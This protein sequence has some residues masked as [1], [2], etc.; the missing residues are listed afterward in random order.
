[1]SGYTGSL[2]IE[3]FEGTSGC[4]S[5]TSID[6]ASGTTPQSIDVTGATASQTYYILVDGVGGT[7]N[8]AFSLD[9]NITSG[10]SNVVEGVADPV[11]SVTPDGG[12][13]PFTANIDNQTL[14]NGTS[15]NYD[16]FI[17]DSNFTLI[18]S[19]S[20]TSGADTTFYFPTIGQYKILLSL[21]NSCL[22]A[23]STSVDL[24]SQ[25]LS[26][27]ITAGYDPICK[28]TP[29]T[30]FPSASLSP[31]YPT[32]DAFP[33]QWEWDFGDPSSGVDNTS[34]DQYPI[35]TF[36]GSGPYVTENFT[37]TLI[38]QADCGPD[39][40]TY[41]I[42]IIPRPNANPNGPL[43]VCS[44][45]TPE[46][47]T[48]ASDGT[49]PYSV[50]W[51]GG[52]GTITSP[53][54]DTTTVTGL[55]VGSY[56]FD[57]DITDGIGCILDSVVDVTVN[58]NPTIDASS[59]TAM[60]VC[61]YADVNLTSVVT[62]SLPYVYDW[63][64]TAY[65]DD[66]SSATPTANVPSSM[67]IY[68]SVTDA[69]GCTSD[70]D[71]VYISIRT[72]PTY[73][74]PFICSSAPLPRTT[75]VTMTGAGVGSTF[76][77]F[78]SPDYSLISGTSGA[79]STVVTIDFSSSTAGDYDFIVISTD[80]VTGCIDTVTV[81]VTLSAGITV[82]ATGP[83]Q[84]CLNDS[85][86]LSA[87]GATS[88]V[89]TV[90]PAEPSL[91]GQD[92]IA[93]PTTLPA[94]AN[95]YTYTVTGTTGQCT[96]EDNVTT[97]VNPLPIVTITTTDDTICLAESA[98]LVAGG[99]NVYDWSSFPNDPSLSGQTGNAAITVTPTVN[100]Q[101]CVTGTD[102]NNCRSGVCKNVIILTNNT[103]SA[104]ADTTICE[105][106][107][108]TLS[109]SGGTTYV[110]YELPG[111]ILVGASTNV[112]VAPAITTEY[113]VESVIS[114]CVFTDT[115]EVT[116]N[117]APAVNITQSEDTICR[118][119][120]LNLSTNGSDIFLWSSTPADGTLAGQQTNSSVTVFP[121]FNTTYSVTVTDTTSGCADTKQ[122]SVVTLATPTAIVAVIDTVCGCDTDTLDGT[123][124]T[125]SM[126]YLWTTTSGSIADSSDLITTIDICSTVTITLTVTNPA[127]GCSSSASTTAVS[128]LLP[129]AVFSFDP[130]QFC[131]GGVITD[132]LD[133][134]GSDVAATY[135]WSSNPAAIS[136]ADSFALITT[137]DVSVQ[138][139]FFLTVTK[140][141]CDS[142]Y[143]DTLE[144][145]PLPVVTANSG[146]LCIGDILLDTFAITGAGAG[147]TYD[148]SSSPD[149]ATIT[150]FD[151]TDSIAYVDYTLFGAGTYNYNIVVVD[152][153][154]GCEDTVLFSFTVFSNSITLTLTNDTT[155]CE[156]DSLQLNVSGAATYVWTSSPADV[157][158][159]GQ[160]SISNPK[161]LATVTTT[162]YVTAYA[163]SCF[164]QDSLLVTVNPIPNIDVGND[165]SI[166]N[167]SNLV[168]TGSGGTSYNWYSLPG[169][170]F[171]GSGVSIIVSPTSLTSFYA[172]GSLSGCSSRDT[173]EVDI[174]PLPLID[175]T[176]SDDTICGGESIFF[177]LIGASTYLWSSA[178]N[179]ASLAGQTTSAN[180]T[181]TPAI[182]TVYTIDG[183]DATTGCSNSTN[184]TVVVNPKPVAAM[185]AIDDI[186]S[187]Q[188]V[189]L[190]GSGSTTSLTYLWTSTSGSIADDT[191]L[192]TTAGICN[193]ST[194]SLIVT[195]TLT[196]CSDTVQTIVNTLTTPNAVISVTSDSFCSGVSTVVTLSGTGS[197]AGATY[198]WTASPSASISDTTALN[199]TATIT[200]TTVFTFT[201][202]KG[203]C[204]SVVTG[205][206]ATFT[207]P[208]VSSNPASL[209]MNDVLTAVFTVNGA[210]SG[211]S[212]DWDDS[213][214]LATITGFSSGNKV[215]DVDFTLFG[216]GTYNYVII[217]TDAVTGCIDTI[218][219]SFT[220]FSNNITLTLTNDTSICLLDTAE[221]I[222]SGAATYAWTASPADASLTGQTTQDT[223]YLSPSA[224]TKYYVTGSAGSCFKNDSV[225]ISILSL[226]I[227]SAGNDDTICSGTSAD[228]SASGTT[229]YEWYSLP[230]DVLIASTQNTSVSPASTTSYFVIGSDGTCSNNDT[231]KINVISSPNAVVTTTDDSLCLGDNTLLQ[232][233]GANTYLWSAV[234]ADASLTGQT[235]LASITVN[236]TVTTT[237][238]VVGTST[239]TGCTGTTNQI[240][241]VNPGLT[242]LAAPINNI[243]GCENV[244][245][246]GTGSTTSNT[247]FLWNSALSSP[248]TDDSDLTTTA[249]VCGNDII[250]LTVT[251]TIGNCSAIDTQTVTYFGKPDVDF[252]ANPSQICNGVATL[253]TL[254]GIADAGQTYE[255][256]SNPVVT[257]NNSNTLNATTTIS[258][259][260]IFSLKVTDSNGC[261]STYSDTVQTFSSPDITP[262]P[263]S[264]CESDILLDTLTISGP[265]TGSTID[266]SASPDLASITGFNAANTKA[267]TDYT[268]F[269]AG[270]YDYIITITDAITGCVDV[271]NY[272]FT[273]FPSAMNL[274]LSSDPSAICQND[275]S[276][277]TVSGA[278]TYSWSAS[279][280]DGSLSGQTTEDTIEVSPSSTT[281]YIVVGSAG[282]CTVTDTI[283]LTVLSIP[284]FDLGP[285]DTIICAGA[286]ISL[287]AS[288]GGT[289]QWFQ[290]PQDSLV[291]TSQILVKT[292][293]T[294][295]TYYVIV[296]GTN[297]CVN[298]DTIAISVDPIPNLNS[299]IEQDT[300]CVHDTVTFTAS[301]TDSFLWSALPSDVT[302]TG[303]ETD[304]IINV[305]PDTTTV[306]TLSGTTG[307]CT[308]D[309]V[310]TLN[311]KPGPTITVNESSDS[312]CSKATITLT[313]SGALAYQ[314]TATP[315]DAT[316]TG[317]ET[318][319][320]INVNPEN[321]TQYCAKGTD[322]EGCY[323]ISCKTITTLPLPTPD[324]GNDTTVC[325]D[326]V[327]T[328]TASGG[329]SYQW[330]VLSNDSLIG[331]SSIVNTVV[332]DTTDYYVL[333]TAANGC[334]N[335]DTVKV[336]VIPFNA[337][338]SIS[339]DTLCT[340]ANTVFTASG[341]DT[342]SWSA[343]PADATL[344]L[345]ESTSSTIDVTPLV[346]TI[347]TLTMTNNTTGCDKQNIY[348][349]PVYAYPAA[350]AAPI[351]DNCGCDAVTLDG[352]G[353]APLLSYLWISYSG[354]AVITNS[355]S[356]NASAVVCQDD[357]LQIIVTNTFTG[358]VSV[359]TT[360][361]HYIPKPNATADASPEQFCQ[362]VATTITLSGTVDSAVSYLWTAVPSVVIA[363]SSQ[364]NTT[365]IVSSET[366]FTLTLTNSSG[367]DTSIT[368]TVSAYPAPDLIATPHSFCFSNP[369][370]DLVMDIVGAS[371]GSTYNWFNVPACVTPNVVG[372]VSSQALNFDAC[373]AGY[374]LFEVEITDGFTGCVDSI[375][376]IVEIADSVSLVLDPEGPL[377]ICED[378]SL[379]ITAE[380]AF[381]FYWSTGDSTIADTISAV[382]VNPGLSVGSNNI[383]VTGVTGNCIASDTVLV[384][385]IAMPVADAG[386]N[387]T[388]CIDDTL[389]LTASNAGIGAIYEWYILPEDSLIGSGQSL[390]IYHDTTLTY[391]YYIKVTQTSCVSAD[392]FTV[393]VLERPSVSIT[394]DADTVCYGEVLTLIA[395]PTGNGPFSYLWNDSDASTSQIVTP[396]ITANFDFCVLLTDNSSGCTDTA[397]KTTISRDLPVTVAAAET[398]TSCESDD[399][400]LF[401]AG[402]HIYNW[403]N[404][405][406]PGISLG[407]T[408]TITVS[409]IVSACYVLTGTDTTTGCENKDTVCLIV[410]A[411]PIAHAGT[412]QSICENSSVTLS[413]AL[414]SNGTI[415]W[416]NTGNGFFDDDNIQN[417]IYTPG[418]GDA[419]TTVTLT[420]TVSNSP[421]VDAVSTIDIAVENQPFAAINSADPNPV[422]S[423]DTVDLSGTVTFGTALWY[424]DGNGLLKNQTT[425]TPY[426]ISAISDIGIVNAYM[427][428]TGLLGI[429]DDAL[430]SVEIEIKGIP[431]AN[432]GVNDAICEGDVKIFADASYNNGGIIWNTSGNGIFDSD[433]IEKPTYTHGS[434]DIG[435]TIW[436]TM[437]VTNAPCPTDQ[438]TSLL[439]IDPAPIAIIDSIAEDTICIDDHVSIYGSAL[440]VIGVVEWSDG[441]TAGT[442]TNTNG[443]TTDYYPSGPGVVQIYFTVKGAETCAPAIDTITLLVKAIPTAD[444][445]SGYPAICENSPLLLSGATSSNGTVSWTTTGSG[446]FNDSTLTN[447]TYTPDSGEAGF[448][449]LTIGVSNDPCQEAID[450]VT[451]EISPAPTSAILSIS[452]NH[453]CEGTQVT[454]TAAS[455]NA[456]NGTAWSDDNGLGTFGSKINSTTTT[457]DAGAIGNITIYYT[458]TGSST[459]TSAVDSVILDVKAPPYAYI[460]GISKD[461]TCVGLPI[462]IDDSLGN[463]NI[464]WITSGVG[465]F[466]TSTSTYTPL[467]AGIAFLTVFVTNSPCPSASAS[468][469]LVTVPMPEVTIDPS[470]TTICFADT[471]TISATVDPNGSTVT[472]QWND[473]NLAASASV[474]VYPADTTLYILYVLNDGCTVQDSIVVNVIPPGTPDAGIDTFFCSGDAITLNGNIEYASKAQW[475][476]TG[477]G[478]FTPGNTSLNTNY[479][480]TSSES[481]GDTLSFWLTTTDACY[482]K[483]DTIEIEILGKGTVDAGPDQSI[484]L[485]ANA[486]LHGQIN[487]EGN[488]VWTSSGT[489]D[490]YP[491]DT[492]RNAKYFP[493]QSDYENMPITLTFSASTP[494]A[495]TFDAMTLNSDPVT[496]PTVV[497]P[498]PG[499]PGQN[500]VLEIGGIEPG[501]A[502]VII[503]NKWGKKVFEASNY[504]NNWDAS[505]VES[506]VYY[507]VV[508]YGDIEKSA[509]IMILREEE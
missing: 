300:M 250:T 135:E 286:T 297:T 353:S 433:T 136:I 95:T 287:T 245:L 367:C 106:D 130:T 370:L 137:A 290:L 29:V 66:P 165:T 230:A 17:F 45:E 227:V 18:S 312:I 506:N 5:L 84:A 42:S 479:N 46:L 186:C 220:V 254:S 35:H 111:N 146:S 384:S 378:D 141:G 306:Y 469:K 454:L 489:G 352:S 90:S 86:S 380:G 190:D 425:A 443:Y 219:Y 175:V 157:S 63:Y 260:T 484:S 417:P 10:P 263:A 177:S 490:F 446:S 261:D 393:T 222:I 308:I 302:L 327:A 72:P 142:V 113:F 453:I 240:I 248:I 217:V 480:P 244:I 277:I 257:I 73:S 278:A 410:N 365:A 482:N 375:S 7:N 325:E 163:G 369:P 38:T 311:V 214:D 19:V 346:T 213:P 202:S 182:T 502:Q 338:V 334:S 314:W 351:G 203:G 462:I 193:T 93:S 442:F 172:E 391:T 347:Y 495:T 80:G 403:E 161:I 329:V 437:T 239:L 473:P 147:S 345:A 167:G 267:Y 164:S 298:A 70:T 49:D 282:S 387:T 94:S 315:A 36:V 194:I 273:V 372:N 508:K 48:V 211:S 269:G 348:T 21:N 341:A 81:T 503:F 418:G 464:Q 110:W 107:T 98:V 74:S 26:T 386:G 423:G 47:I 376:Q 83:S 280:A 64:P 158:L 77:W 408:D 456:L 359:D 381:N 61:R 460:N 176:A 390:N 430:D 6:C 483:T 389:T 88:Y 414:A 444:A 272:S 210:A 335:R 209:C 339:D 404:V 116:V 450:S 195:D 491:S 97:V 249:L 238:T 500:D 14:T 140:D 360:T 468:K 319:S 383:I 438:D 198:Q 168:L 451:I 223:L 304:N 153:V 262:S 284:N 126:N 358:C 71:S 188:T 143:S 119:S 75:D 497:T 457:Y 285:A 59:L 509:W 350:D 234:P 243:C 24:G 185:A 229:S 427:L 493:S 400:R 293:L 504:R 89:W 349:I 191:S 406:S 8:T 233:V 192:V 133:G 340:G 169:N 283:K 39:T 235:T 407:T 434:V 412:D 208:T 200:Q 344:S 415:I 371:V 79:D 485:G 197:A 87:N 388:A 421:C 255:W 170:D 171:L 271:I 207:I 162:Y 252:T 60:P 303:Q 331:S 466:D 343:F 420:L 236:P 494:C 69:T 179:D 475:G 251:D 507:Y 416:T 440:N 328:L 215:A 333:A 205:T 224:T 301:G 231:V 291:S 156:N 498:Y 108:L 452:S 52:A 109:A 292:L 178:P 196:A 16:W 496:L 132:T 258:S 181:V 419:G 114:G 173:I 123:G 145:Y 402:T 492:A 429:C 385:V 336:N 242:A 487:E 396:T 127:K 44:G 117:P 99:A 465:T 53:T 56:T 449:T 270:T 65:L 101:Y 159:N 160:D 199:T 310:Y 382:L 11:I 436:F 204:D 124:S 228:L 96:N 55:A 184:Y 13:A 318:A 431:T 470:D 9:V 247:V 1:M 131:G 474:D 189:D 394:A 150:G 12:C 363:D 356:Q 505:N 397:C 439:R 28:G 34:T 361:V 115:L 180:P 317:Q 256:T 259:T 411:N 426:Y 15:E 422:C 226:P 281:N 85:I 201:V 221:I 379:E 174:D 31:S 25:A 276:E 68:G 33:Y 432:A 313:A 212:Y 67:Y 488:G 120:A 364:L 405:T 274:T 122:A 58:T 445:G 501:I 92:S 54:N 265:S 401:A 105:N 4:G 481:N 399:V 398:D 246:D 225:S 362:G 316:L 138:T 332:Y 216:A 458:A 139:I 237:Y 377:I 27:S 392:T 366:Y 288:G 40:T 459:C 357:T 187:C 299:S 22:V 37:I 477:A 486:Q 102:N 154:T 324:A 253:I 155:V 368:D 266:W 447:A 128:K 499:S 50:V 218:N 78:L 294:D 118:G 455:T 149:S 144:A 57:L 296:T 152:G 103:L 342:Y 330:Y 321:T 409:P 275:T 241:V 183:T 395:N 322:A 76:K 463:G 100:T 326:D 413:D 2:T 30:F 20:N 91:N 3:I 309:H 51:S 289:Y 134:A 307:A 82:T 129:D 320:T 121:I 148:W 373:P 478:T 471:I 435:S 268:T 62:G 472:Y 206:S 295:V 32:S 112:D 166:C 23:G 264:L 467:A 43:N 305:S 104:G 125:T 41:D 279:P 354:N 461:T 374:H 337:S 476:T 151:A 355:T 448:I 441:S 323:N 428:V 424:T 232:V